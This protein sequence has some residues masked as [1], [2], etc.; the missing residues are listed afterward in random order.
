MG[1]PA[2]LGECAAEWE[3]EDARLGCL[4]VMR[5][6]L[7]VALAR[8]SR[9]LVTTRSSCG[10]VLGRGRHEMGVA[11]KAITPARER[12]STHEQGKWFPRVK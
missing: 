6:T 10:T 5:C 12:N 9:S 4:E 3:R 11:V 7:R 2:A 1:E 8:R